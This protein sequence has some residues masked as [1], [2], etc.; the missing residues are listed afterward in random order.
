[1]DATFKYA[2][3][4]A[5]GL[6]IGFLARETPNLVGLADVARLDD[7]RIRIEKVFVPAMRGAD[8]LLVDQSSAASVGEELDYRIAQRVGTLEGWR[9][10]LAAH[11]AGE[12]APAAKAEMERLLAAERPVS[13][14]T[15]E[16]VALSADEKPWDEAAPSSE[17]SP[18]QEPGT[19]A[20]DLV[21]KPAQSSDTT[22]LERTP[23]PDVGTVSTDAKSA[24]EGG[25]PPPPPALQLEV[26]TPDVANDAAGNG[27]APEKAETPAP[28]VL[29]PVAPRPRSSSAVLSHGNRTRQRASRCH[30]ARGCSWHPYLPPIILAL[31]GERP[32]RPGALAPI[33]HNVRKVAFAGR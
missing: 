15:A 6:A 1:M 23:S 27:A 2:V 16:A 24:G 28:T 7:M 20:P 4:L 25:G 22:P 12:Y 26:T 9:A 17:R 5:T 10:F 19:H 30:R 11:S 13:P 29:P 14:S 8:V 3:V 32:G 33:P 21:N 18:A 31:L